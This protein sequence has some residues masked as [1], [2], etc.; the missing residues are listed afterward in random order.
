MNLKISEIKPNIFFLT[1]TDQYDMCMF[2]LR[3]QEFYESP[4]P[5]FRNKQFQILD[6]MKWY[7]KKY[8]NG[9]FTYTTDWGGFNIPSSVIRDVINNGIQDRNI[10]DYEM[11]RI[12]T[13]CKKSSNDFYII[14]ALKNHT[15]TIAHETAHGFFFLNQEYKT[16]ATKLVKALPKEIRQSI[17]YWL[18]TKGYTPKVYIDETQAYLST[19][20][21]SF[22]FD[23]KLN[24]V[25]TKL[26]TPF[27]K[28]FK[29]Y[30]G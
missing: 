9:N 18:K 20:F 14:G 2:F 3:Y 24:N 13:E 1:F 8:G 22:N 4:S 6:F 28:L 19:G 30:N 25:L 7:S 16:Q 11:K 17:N 10:Y 27:V 23:N 21:S 26:S 15:K 5:K 29:S 12:Y